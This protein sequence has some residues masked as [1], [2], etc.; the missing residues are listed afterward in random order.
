MPVILILRRQR[1]EDLEQ[2][3]QHSKFQNSQGYIVRSVSEED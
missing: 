1:Q 3:D 2:A